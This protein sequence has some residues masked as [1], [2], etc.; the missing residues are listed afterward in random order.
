MSKKVKTRPKKSEPK[1]M[2]H[3]SKPEQLKRITEWA[4]QGLSVHEIAN[5]IGIAERTLYNWRQK[6]DAIMQALTKGQGT[7]VEIL[8]NA[9]FKRAIGY[10]IEETTYRFDEDGNKIPQRVQTKHIYPDVTA[11]KFALINKSGGKW[12]DRVE[13]N[14][15][16]AHNKLDEMLE[17]MKESAKDE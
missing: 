12:A 2:Q 7:A 4:E 10:D 8:E 3:W 17:K 14:D 1:S 11:L 6:E 5:N 16:S 13:Y 15:Q 9:L